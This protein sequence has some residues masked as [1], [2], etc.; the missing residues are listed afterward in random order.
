VG[1]LEVNSLVNATSFSQY[2]PASG[3][4]PTGVVPKLEFTEYDLKGNLLQANTV[5]DINNSFI[6]DY[7]GSLPIAKIANARFQDVAYT[8]FEA[9]GKGNWVYSGT[10]TQDN[11][12]PTG[13]KVYQI[14]TT[15]NLRKEN[16]TP[17]KKYIVCV[18]TKDNS[19]TLS[20]SNT[21]NS[22]PVTT[23]WMTKRTQGSWRLLEATITNVDKVTLSSTASTID[24]L[25]LYPTEAQ[26][27]TVTY[28]P[29]IG[30]TNECDLNNK[31]TYYEY[32]PFGRLKLIRDHDRNILKTIQYKYQEAQQ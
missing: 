3:H 22:A 4:Y 19:P 28:D 6:W 21:D 11:L 10:S 30:V 9:D 20:G 24:E 8:S 15:S 1:K 23:Q 16:L 14:T 7:Q 17:Q 2:Q 32:D 27:N 18:W 5:N 26:M 25:R 12:A 13:N 29:L 31:I